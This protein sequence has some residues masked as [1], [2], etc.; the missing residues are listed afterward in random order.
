[1][2]ASHRLTL[3]GFLKASHPVVLLALLLPACG[4]SPDDGAGAYREDFRQVFG[5]GSSGRDADAGSPAWAIVLG[6]HSGPGAMDRAETAAAALRERLDLRSARAA[7]RRNGAV[8][9]F[10]GYDAPSDRDAQRDLD[11]LQS[12][13]VDDAQPF[14]TAFLAPQG[15]P[16]EGSY[17][18]F[19]LNN[20]RAEYGQGARYTLQIAVYES[21]ERRDAMDAAEQAVLELRQD[22]E[23]AFYF[24]GPTKS[25]VTVG[26]F[27]DRDYNPQTGRQSSELQALQQRYPNNLLNG[28]TIIERR[29]EGQRTQPSTLVAVPE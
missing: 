2:T 26:L 8:V 9:L 21:P 19:N 14:R 1:M 6:V 3:F 18:Q 27:G 11:R 28:R 4:S 16:P 17:P 25:M 20:A 29:V 10:G 23:L 5:S 7:P 13:R 24:H 15:G 12:L 22:G